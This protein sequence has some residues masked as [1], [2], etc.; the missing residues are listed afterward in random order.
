M[1]N[2]EALRNLAN[3]GIGL[4][5]LSLADVKTYFYSFFFTL[6]N[7]KLLIQTRIIEL[8]ASADVENN[9]DEIEEK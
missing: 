6:N 3:S 5:N 1:R 2:E 7:I 4:R 8:L 9:D